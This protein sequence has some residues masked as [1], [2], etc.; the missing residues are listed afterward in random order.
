M[1]GSTANR[2]AA[3]RASINLTAIWLQNSSF[4]MSIKTALYVSF[5]LLTVAA[6]LFARERLAAPSTISFRSF[7]ADRT[8]RRQSTEDFVPKG[9]TVRVCSK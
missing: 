7:F 2:L 6:A 5:A 9:P 3:E 1:T 4:I 8:H